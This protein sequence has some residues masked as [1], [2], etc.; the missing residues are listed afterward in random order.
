MAGSDVYLGAV[1]G[2]EQE[3]AVIAAV[4]NHRHIFIGGKKHPCPDNPIYI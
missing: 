4:L 1:D 3:I 2:L